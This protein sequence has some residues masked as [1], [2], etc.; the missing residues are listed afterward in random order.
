MNAWDG[1]PEVGREL[2]RRG[3]SADVAHEALV[4]VALARA[5]GVPIR[6]VEAFAATAARRLVSQERARKRPG[7]LALEP[8]AAPELERHEDLH[9]ALALLPAGDRLL[10]WRAHVEGESLADLAPLLGLSHAGARSRVFRARRKLRRLLA[11]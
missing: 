6:D 4:R 8:V 7:E 9:A 11:L 10:L 5:R 2:V 3:Y 1:L